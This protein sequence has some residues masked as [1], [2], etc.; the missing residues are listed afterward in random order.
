MEKRHGFRQIE[1]YSSRGISIT[2]KQAGSRTNRSIFQK[3][4]PTM[5]TP[6]KHTP[7]AILKKTATEETR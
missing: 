3:E 5:P 2:G 4:R 1:N 7:N 6:S